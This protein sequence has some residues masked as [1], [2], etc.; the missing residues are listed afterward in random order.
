M[1]SNSGIFCASTLEQSDTNQ[2]RI[3]KYMA[4]MGEQV[5]MVSEGT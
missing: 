5:E 1:V 4:M 3:L 2:E